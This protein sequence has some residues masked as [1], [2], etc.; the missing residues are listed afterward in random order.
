MDFHAA[1]STA[2]NYRALTSEGYSQPKGPQDA[3]YAPT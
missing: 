1:N 2:V 3:A